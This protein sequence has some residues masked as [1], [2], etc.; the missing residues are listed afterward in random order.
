MYI[1]IIQYK[2]IHPRIPLTTLILKYICKFFKFCDKYYFV[3]NIVYTLKFLIT[4]WI[5]ENNYFYY[6]SS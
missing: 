4:C 3:I 5:F 1:N 6:I 2:N